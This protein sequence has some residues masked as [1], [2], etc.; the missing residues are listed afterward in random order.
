MTG[1][2]SRKKDHLELTARGDVGFRAQGTLLSDV[3]L[4]HDALPELHVDD[5]DLSCVVLGKRLR[6]PI[7]IAAMTGGTDHAGK[8]NR[9]L[10]KI[11]EARGYAMGFGS[12]RP[13]LLNEAAVETYTVRDVA[14]DLL[15]LG[16]VGAVQASALEPQA[17]SKLVNAVGADALCV[18]LN[19]AMEVVQPE[20]DKDFRGCLPQI[21]RLAREL[22]FPIVA[23]ETGCGI[24]LGVAQRLA[25]AGVEHVDVSG[26][27]G[28][29]WVG[30]ETLRAQGE[31]RALGELF[32]DWGIPTAASVLATHRVGFR[33]VFATG[34]LKTGLDVARAIVLGATAGGLAR[35]VIQAYY[36]GGPEAVERYLEQVERELRTA[37]L[38]VGAGNLAQLQK[39][40]RLIGGSLREWDM[41][42]ANI[43]HSSSS[44]ATTGHKSGRQS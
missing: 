21:A 38:L 8:I 30:V 12:Q 13:M 15:L 17:I 36:D 7:L 2:E 37:M 42:W 16:N 32:W 6:A 33:T 19:P 26:A 43:Q 28:T 10:A 34:G 23:K 11:A 9:D 35:P 24:S 29:S 5:I 22:P 4:V 44:L 3:Q 14:P 25:A 20:G 41:L 40:P 27:G 18:H 39:V 31:G 1:I